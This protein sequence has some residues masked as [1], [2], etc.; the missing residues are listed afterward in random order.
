MV[1]A[2]HFR[3]RVSTQKTASRSFVRLGK[4]RHEPRRLNGTGN[5]KE[6]ITNRPKSPMTTQAPH[7][8]IRIP[9]IMNN[10]EK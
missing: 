1:G 6:L 8:F 2:M 4:P 7:H 9:S 5:R 3:L 10:V